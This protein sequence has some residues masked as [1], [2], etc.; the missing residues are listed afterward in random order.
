MTTTFGD[1]ENKVRMNGLISPAEFQY[2]DESRGTAA[3]RW[4]GWIRDFEV[5]LI[6]A[7]INKELKRRQLCYT[8]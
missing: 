6:A 4:M 2:D 8:W 3:I 7:G 5:F 1:E